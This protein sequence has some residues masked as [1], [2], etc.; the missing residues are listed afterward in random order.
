[1]SCRPVLGRTVDTVSEGP[2]QTFTCTLCER[3]AGVI[4]DVSKLIVLPPTAEELALHEQYL[5]AL[6]KETKGPSLW[7][8][9]LGPA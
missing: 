7:R 2:Q 1:M 4:L 5:D 6:E 9:I 8:R 3:P